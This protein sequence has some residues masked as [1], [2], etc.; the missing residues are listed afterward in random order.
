MNLH[1]IQPIEEEAI[2]FSSETMTEI[3]RVISQFPSGKEKSSILGVLHLVQT[4]L[5]WLS[6][7][8]MK[9]V[10]KVLQIEPIEVYE[11]A[12]FYTMFHLNPVGQNVLEVC[13]TGPCMIVGSDK[14]IE[15]IENKLKI[16]VGETTADGL[17][18]LKTVECLGA[19]G[20]GPMLQCKYKF[21]ENLTTEKIDVMLDEMKSNAL[22]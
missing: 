11:V 22:K 9:G 12:S 2:L 17:F 18:T 4:E 15:Y 7:G 21:Y 8:A 13:R 10:A 1:E 5:G 6:V 20:Y 3:N 14:I 16:K 19:C